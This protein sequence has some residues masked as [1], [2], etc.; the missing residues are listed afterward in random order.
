MSTARWTGRAGWAE[1][2][3]EG[4]SVGPEGLSLPEGRREGSFHAPVFLPEEGF[5][6]AVP[7]WNART[8]PGERVVVRAR[9][10]RGGAPLGDWVRAATWSREE[11]GPR[12]AGAGPVKIDQD[13][14]LIEGGADA[15]EVRATLERDTHE[16]RGPV[17]ARLGVT[18]FSS[19][20][21]V[22]EHARTG[23]ERPPMRTGPYHTQR[24][25][26]PEIAMRICGPTS[27]A[28]AL[29]ACGIATGPATVA[30]AARDPDGAIAFGNWAYLCATAAEHGLAAEVVSMR[31]LG[32]LARALAGDRLAILS[33]SFD[34]GELS[35]APIESTAGHLVLARGFDE[36]GNV[37]V[38][39]PAGRGEADGRVRYRPDELA[40][41]WKRGIAIV[42][43][44]VVRG[45]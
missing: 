29:G 15:I 24:A 38:D 18:T 9:A 20:R 10:M 17:L 35:G 14:L 30:R 27:L 5:D 13:T 37:V 45:R 25:E 31:D 21:P 1:G 43:E 23:D 11:R 41:A 26:D 40:R 42:L 32:E 28:M 8:A 6:R 34:K 22:P 2:E 36:H 3:L 12:D 16:G 7:F 39:D 4:L 19:K 33:L 44:P